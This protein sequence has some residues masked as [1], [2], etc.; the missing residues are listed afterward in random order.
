PGIP[1]AG[2]LG[3]ED[4]IGA[5]LE[6][7]HRLYGFGHRLVIRRTKWLEERFSIALQTDGVGDGRVAARHLHSQG[8]EASGA[9]VAA[10]RHLL[11]AKSQ[12]LEPAKLVVGEVRKT[13][14]PQGLRHEREVLQHHSLLQRNKFGHKLIELA[15]GHDAAAARIVFQMAAAAA[16]KRAEAGR[17]EMVSL[18][19][20]EGAG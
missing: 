1:G 13:A 5:E 20:N 12:R 11:H 17:Q 19:D 9:Q 6:L 3:A 10:G 18:I 2:L 7:Y 8:G 14:Q 16:R 4:A 15:H